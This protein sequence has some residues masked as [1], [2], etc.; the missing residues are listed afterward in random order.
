M[1]VA[2]EFI[3]VIVPISVIREKY[4][5]GWEQ[6]LKDHEEILGGA[7]WYDEHLFR[8]G[9]MSPLDAEDLVGFWESQGLEP[10]GEEGGQRFWKDCCVVE[11][12]FGGVTLPCSWIE[13]T[14]DR[15]AAFLAGTEPGQI[16]Y[17]SR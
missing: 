5:G 3:D 12:M 8:T 2:L 10:K 14:E 15:S 16:V 13:L 17:P 9:A 11:G 4:R 1:A 7:A 6:C